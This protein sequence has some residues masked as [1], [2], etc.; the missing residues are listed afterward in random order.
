MQTHRPWSAQALAEDHGAGLPTSLARKPW[1][2]W[3]LGRK[4]C[5]FCFLHP[6]CRLRLHRLHDVMWR[7]ACLVPRR[8]SSKRT[9]RSQSR[10]LPEVSAPALRELGG[11]KQEIAMGWLVAEA[12]KVAEPGQIVFKPHFQ[13]QSCKSKLASISV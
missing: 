3:M 8:C 10:N 12:E 5:P 2:S 6:S 1:P 4:R 11:V 9:C 7:V 13:G